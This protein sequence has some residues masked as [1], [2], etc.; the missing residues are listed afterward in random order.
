MK[1]R[2]NKKR[3]TAFI[4]EALVRE[5]TVAILK[6]NAPRR[7]EVVSIIKKH[8][9]D[10][11]QLKQQ[12]ECYRSLYEVR[13][14][15]EAM[16]RRILNEAKM[17]SR[18][19]DTNGLFNSQSEL[20]DDVNKSVSPEV[21][22]NFV[23]NYK[24]LATISQM[25]SS[26]T[27]PRDRV[28]LENQ[29]IKAMTSAPPPKVETAGIDNITYKTFV[30]KFNSKYGETLLQEQKELLTKYIS[31]FGDNALELKM[32]LNTEIARLKSRMIEAMSIEEIKS[33]KEMLKKTTAVVERLTS[34]AKSEV[35]EEVLMAVLKTQSLV[36]EI[37]NGNND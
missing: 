18:M 26:K 8:F 16:A 11:S 35:T 23:P 2:H 14:I 9:R 29:I 34:Y 24:T 20:I 28:I 6:E 32:Y 36:E 15:S 3:N 25:F 19:L 13:G 4:Y 21:F 12:L 22:N 1:T 17:A 7:N 33:D 27:S 31:S 10:D 37:Y 30:G 5:A